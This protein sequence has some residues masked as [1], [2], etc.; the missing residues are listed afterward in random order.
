M[1][2]FLR[3]GIDVTLLR[4]NRIFRA[5]FIGRMLT[6]FGLSMLVVTVNVQ[7]YALTGSSLHIAL[8]NSVLG[9]CSVAGSF[10]GGSIADRV[11]RRIVI[12]VTR[13]L[14]VFGFAAL[15]L[16]AMLPEASLAA[17]YVITAFD[18]AIGSAGAAAFGAAIPAVVRAEELPA[19]GAIMALSIDLGA[20]AAPALAGVLIARF[21]PALVLWIV[22]GLGIVSWL[23]ICRIPALS[24]EPADEPAPPTP[25]GSG[26][27]VPAASP[28]TDAQQPDAS[29]AGSTAP[30]I[31][32]LR[33]QLRQLRTHTAEAWAFSRRDRVVGTVLLIGFIQILFASPF[34]LIP[35][36]V[37][38]ALGGGSAE[39]GLLYSAPACGALLAGLSSG[40]IARRSRLSV[41]VVVVFTASA[42]GVAAFGQST[43]LWP[44]F[45]F[46]AVVGAGDVIGE[47]LRFTIISSR[48]PDRLRGRIT[49]LWQAQATV[50]DTL[51]GPLLS[52]A[53]RVLGAGAA[54]SIGGVIAA[55]LTCALLTRSAVRGHVHSNR[56]KEHA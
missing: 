22:V 37:A 41:I 50:G 54:I 38:T 13:G 4:S 46:L 36:F 14:A 53:A 47:I 9:V 49:G 56:E 34:V 7:I 40:W 43:S 20:A 3:W 17:I 30:M 29:P 25:A 27:A 26:A 44:A 23:T 12:L 52:L 55:V 5:L 2:F 42:L 45:A 11:D 48:T 51:G 33:G 19:T 31:G 32:W 1:S 15:A 8:V 21:D 16:N 18:A 10:I 28:L 24:P 39:V 35:E 6:V